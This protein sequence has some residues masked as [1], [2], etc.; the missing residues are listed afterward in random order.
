MRGDR[1][2]IA[3]ATTGTAASMTNSVFLNKYFNYVYYAGK[4]C[5][6][7][8]SCITSMHVVLVLRQEKKK[9]R[10]Q[11]ERGEKKRRKDKKNI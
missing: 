8:V 6:F 9:E 11:K 1:S 4:D 3:L 7:L 5:V 10:K 2:F